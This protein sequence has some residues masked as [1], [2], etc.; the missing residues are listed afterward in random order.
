MS[1]LRGEPAPVRAFVCGA[2]MV[3]LLLAPGLAAAQG[4]AIGG[5]VSDETGGV[6]PG[7]TVEARSPAII[8]QVRTAV[9]DGNGQYLIVALEP[10][11]Y[12]VT[13]SLPGFSTLIREGIEL[14]IGFTASIDVQL[15]VGDIQETVTVTGDSPVVDIQNV[16]QRQVMD[17]EVID[18]I[19]TGKSFFNYALLVPGM[20]SSESFLT[21]LGQDM[22]GVSPTTL[23][24]MSIHGGSNLDQQL[25]VNGMD[26]GD[27]LTQGAAWSVFPDSNFE[28]MSIEYS[29][30][31]ADIETGGVR[32]NMIPREG[33]N[34]FSGHFFSTFTWPE[35]NADNVDADLTERGL[36]GGTRIDQVWQINPVFGGPLVQDRLWFFLTHTTQRGN[37]FPAS[38]FHDT[39][40]GAFVYTPDLDNPALNV[41]EVWEQSLNLTWQA[42]GRDKV[43]LYWTNSATNQPWWGTGRQLSCC[44]LAPSSGVDVKVRTNTYQATWTRPQTNRLLFEAG[45]SHLPVQH[46]LQPTASAVTTLPGILEFAPVTAHRNMSGWFSGATQRR[47]P[48]MTNF[49]RGS[50]SYV[51]G[52]HNLKFGMSALF[53][54]ENT[55][56]GSENDWTNLNTFR[57]FPIR[58][59]FRTPGVGT[60]RLRPSLGIYAQEQWTLDRLTINAGLRYDYFSSD[61]PDQVLRAS[62]WAPQDFFI[63]GQTAVAWHDLQP[64]VGIAYDLSGDG[65]TAL[66]LSANRAGQRDGTDWSGAVNPG[67]TNTSQTRSWNDG[68][69]GC[70]DA[71][72]I[73]G[74]GLPQGDPMN[75]APN[76]ELLTPNPNPAFGRPIITDVFDRGWS[77][78]WGNRLSNWEVSASVQRELAAGVSL[79]VGYFRRAYVNFAA[80]DDMAVGPEDFDTATLTIPNDSRLPN[81]GAPITLVDKK[82]GSIRLPDRVTTGA[83]DFGG[84]SRTWQGFDFTLD[85]RLRDVLFQGGVSTGAFSTDRCAQV[86]ALPE[87]LNAESS[88]DFCSTDQ[89]WL[90]QIK[91]LTSYTLPYDIQIAATLQNQQGPERLANVTF[92]DAQISAALGRPSVFGSQTVN[93]I[94]PGTVYGERYSQLDLR[95]TKIFTFAGGTRLRTMFD[96]FNLFN[97]NAVTRENPGCASVAGGPCGDSWLTPQVI[98]LGR[99]AKFAF[100]FDF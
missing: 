42:T 22:G 17:R 10:G 54:Q 64:R 27:S 65:R 48:K 88:P 29:G 39:D 56:N 38:V 3:C 93:V 72:C 7:V 21:P 41:T 52:S 94:P 55:F 91:F 75:P 34:E 32:I 30:N 95:F 8:E 49:V 71:N 37:L 26:V 63:E 92:T 87:I 11:T 46:L 14:S 20:E 76:G 9:T 82:P 73:P 24:Q 25:E 28:E 99:L 23:Q 60:N 57:G 97:A 77:H 44:Y 62:A 86:A 47:S 83:G 40:P 51:T 6:L 79:D 81:A 96:I 78:G 33:A 68:I 85:A 90:T 5:T 36:I 59:T 53:L 4:S 15:A 16:E 18:S 19:P 70:V 100:Q 43:K 45:A 50:V 58:A 80:R 74:D 84:E 13:Y 98:M 67:Q 35:L 61:Y 89:A 1:D 12:S 66:K 2:S 69:T 31:S